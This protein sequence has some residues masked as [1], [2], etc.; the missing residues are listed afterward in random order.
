M[1]TLAEKMRKARERVVP[2]GGHKYTVRIPT[3]GELE[4]LHEGLD[5]R[6]ATARRVALAFTVDW[7]LKEIDLITGGTPVAA[8]FDRPVVREHLGADPDLCNALFIAISDGI[9]A[10]SARAQADEKN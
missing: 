7:D 6:R 5:G 4:E 3:P 8:K 10:R 1:S 2:Y 9:E